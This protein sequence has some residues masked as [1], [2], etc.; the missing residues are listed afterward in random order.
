MNVGQAWRQAQAALQAAGLNPAPHEGQT[1][2]RAVLGWPEDA[3]IL[4]ELAPWTEVQVEVLA[5]LMQRR[6]A[7]EPLAYVV[8][9]APFWAR[10][11]RVGTGVL[12][13]RP[14]TELLVQQA[15]LRGPVGAARVAEIGVG[16]GAVLGSL[17]A[18]RP[19]WVGVG[20]EI[21]GEAMHWAKLNLH[22]FVTKGRL[23]LVPT[24]GLVGV[25]GPFDLLVVNP[26]YV[27]DAEWRALEP[28]VRDW[29]PRVAL[30]GQTDK[31]EDGLA[32]YRGVLATAAEKLCAGGWLGLEIGWRQGAAV[33]ALAEE[34][35][36]TWH[37]PLLLHDLA[38][39]PRNVWLQLR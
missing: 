5:E 37:A 13:P 11:W 23:R 10:D 1:L 9:R 28:D 21:S 3:L 35:A 14:D 4:R 30:V 19:A 33:T 12:I 16:S 36:H 18:E 2:V 34:H 27:S 38:G 25:E 7:R 31:N 6:L 26:P 39:R 24:D 20:S 15:L 32:P 22:E 17:L 8:G 29:E